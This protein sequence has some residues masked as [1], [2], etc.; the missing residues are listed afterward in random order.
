MIL[1]VFTGV[2]VGG[3]GVG[4][5]VETGGVAVGTGVIVGTGVPV[6]VGV[7][8]GNGVPVGVGVG[9]II[10]VDVGVGVGVNV[11]AGVEVGFGVIV[12]SGVSPGPGVGVGLITGVGLG[13]GVAVLWFPSWLDPPPGFG[14]L[15]LGFFAQA[16]TIINVF[17][18]ISIFK[19][20]FITHLLVKLC[21]A[22]MVWRFTSLYNGRTNLKVHSEI[23]IF[24]S[25][26]ELKK[27][28]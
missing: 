3:G 7:I 1:L 12:G 16:A 18:S 20:H 21:Q 4:V 26:I 5:G 25:L 11:G 23:S 24:S 2:G 9:L 8:V 27:L 15:A 28:I 22:I 6:G 13:V 10:G 19:V 14:V 17:S